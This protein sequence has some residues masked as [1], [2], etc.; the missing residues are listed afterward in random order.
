MKVRVNASRI[1]GRRILINPMK[2]IGKNKMNN[3]PPHFTI[4][5]DFDTIQPREKKEYNDN[6]ALRSIVRRANNANR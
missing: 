4:E 1:Q 3:I 6:N 5:I 2:K